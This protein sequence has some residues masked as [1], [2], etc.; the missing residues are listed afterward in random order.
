MVANGIETLASRHNDGWLFLDEQKRATGRDVDRIIY[1]L[2][3]GN[4]KARQEKD[5]DLRATMT[6]KL[7]WM[8]SG[9]LSAAEFI[10]QGGASSP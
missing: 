8:S 2:S 4:G 6:W 3:D 10:Q 5:G 7:M 9:E 1:M